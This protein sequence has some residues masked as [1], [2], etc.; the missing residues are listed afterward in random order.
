MLRHN[1]FEVS[2]HNSLYIREEQFIIE[3]KFCRQLK[4]KYN[5]VYIQAL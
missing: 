2:L 3:I 1:T 4:P 5:M